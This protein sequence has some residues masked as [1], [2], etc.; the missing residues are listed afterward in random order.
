MNDKPRPLIRRIGI[1][2]FVHKNAMPLI[3][4]TVHVTAKTIQKMP[5]PSSRT[6][7][8]VSGVIPNSEPIVSV[9]FSQLEI[10]LRIGTAHA[11][12]PEGTGWRLKDT[13]SERTCVSMPGVCQHQNAR[14]L[15]VVSCQAKTLDDGIVQWGNGG[16][17]LI[18]IRIHSTGRQATRK[19]LPG[20]AKTVQ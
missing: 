20:V 18:N 14:V 2:R 3:R 7:G 17:G 4:I 15:M 8:L 13:G 12:R 16:L 11:S 19:A 6:S 1:S 10:C 9:V 5:T